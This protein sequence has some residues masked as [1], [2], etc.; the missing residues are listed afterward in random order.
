MSSVP[1]SAGTTSEESDK[2]VQVRFDMH[3]MGR[4]NSTVKY[5]DCKIKIL[6]S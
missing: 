1:A 3:G 5:I 4:P 2:N 6:I